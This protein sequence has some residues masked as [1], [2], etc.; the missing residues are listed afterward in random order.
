MEQ[1]LSAVVSF[2]VRNQIPAARILLLKYQYLPPSAALL[3]FSIHLQTISR[4]TWGQRTIFLQVCTA[5]K[6]K[7]Q[8]SCQTSRRRCKMACGKNEGYIPTPIQNQ[9]ILLSSC[10]TALRGC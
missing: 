8:A 7:G 4:N 10:Q 5:C 1:V 9:G 3:A 6:G 2:L